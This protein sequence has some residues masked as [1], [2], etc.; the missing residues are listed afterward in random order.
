M[1]MVTIDADKCTG[2]GQCAEMCPAQILAASDDRVEVIGDPTDCLGCDSCVT[3]CANEAIRVE[4][5]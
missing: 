4:E 3:V 2:C 5:F 1:F